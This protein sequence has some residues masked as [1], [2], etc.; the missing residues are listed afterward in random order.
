M[1]LLHIWSDDKLSICYVCLQGPMCD[2]LWSDPDDRGGWG[3]SPRGAGYTF[4][5]DISETFNHS[6]ALTLVSRAHQLVMEVCMLVIPSSS[7]HPNSSLSFCYH[8]VSVCRLLNFSHLIFFCCS[9]KQN[10]TWNGLFLDWVYSPLIS[11]N[12]HLL[13]SCWNKRLHFTVRKLTIFCYLHVWHHAVILLIFVSVY[14][15]N[16]FLFITCEIVFASFLWSF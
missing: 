11:Y 5:H 14:V 7:P 13:Q 9:T 10:Q 15:F 12:I 6:N 16:P 8:L 2:L 1:Y 4:G 3:I